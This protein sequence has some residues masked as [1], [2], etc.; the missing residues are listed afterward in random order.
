MHRVKVSRPT[1]LLSVHPGPTLEPEVRVRGQGLGVG[2]RGRLEWKFGK[3]KEF[4]TEEEEVPGHHEQGFR[5]DV[6]VPTANGL[7]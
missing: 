1:S 7:G 3:K 6:P 4:N 5:E 2:S